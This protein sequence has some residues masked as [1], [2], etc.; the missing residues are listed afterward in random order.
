MEELIKKDGKLWSERPGELKPIEF[1]SLDEARKMAYIS[2]IERLLPEDRSSFEQV[3]LRVYEKENDFWSNKIVEPV[4][5]VFIEIDLT[6]TEN[7]VE[8]I[9]E[10]VE[11]FNINDLSQEEIKNMGREYVK[12]YL[13]AFFDKEYLD[14]EIQLKFSSNE[15]TFI[16]AT[17]TF[18]LLDE[19]TKNH[20]SVYKNIYII[21]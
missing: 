6:P 4:P 14:W 11:L 15:K 1:I 18:M 17:S 5:P 13:D 10:I 9:G 19:N 21:Y 16:E 3:I 8:P 12:E 7:I 2:N 20:I